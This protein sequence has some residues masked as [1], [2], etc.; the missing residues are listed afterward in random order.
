MV[1]MARISTLALLAVAACALFAGAAA[2]PPENLALHAACEVLAG[3]SL[4]SE[5]CAAIVDGDLSTAW[6]TYQRGLPERLPAAVRIDL[7][8][9][10]RVGHLVLTEYGQNAVDLVIKVSVDGTEWTD[11]AMRHFDVHGKGDRTVSV[12]LGELQAR[13]IEVHA[14]D[15][16]YPFGIYEVEVYER[17]VEDVAPTSRTQEFGEPRAVSVLPFA[18]E[19]FHIYLFIGQ[20][21]MAGRA[22][23]E[24]QDL[25]VIERTYVLNKRDQWEPAQ[26]WPLPESSFQD[27]QGLNRYSTVEVLTKLNGLN[28]A[29]YFAKTLVLNLPEIGVGIV[30]NAKGNTAISEWAPGSELYREAVRRTREAMRYG[31]LKGILWHQGESD[32]TNPAYMERLAALIESLRR[33]LG[34]PDLPFIAGE[35][36]TAGDP[37]KVEASKQFNSRLATLPD[38][39]PHTAVA[40][41]AGL[42]DIGDATHI[43]ADGQRLLGQRYAVLALELV[44]DMAGDEVQT[45]LIDK[46]VTPPR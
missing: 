13:Y 18:K 40:S 5:G 23:V 20:S 41:A 34:V 39:V 30:S 45:P 42:R 17:G 26:P 1:P 7:G 44:Y 24:H 38:L 19:D 3:G 12:P 10:R 31:T 14:V 28:P 8:E 33:D 22:P 21:N 11:A 16:L 25:A 37:Q 2:A 15:A 9:V 6:R 43:D 46:A 32:R 35:I 27:M 36:L 4:W 29:S